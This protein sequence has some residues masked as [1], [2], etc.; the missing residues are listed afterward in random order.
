MSR[1]LEGRNAVV[2][3]A[4]RGIGFA[5]AAAFAEHGADVTIT[6]IDVDGG[7]LAESKLVHAG[8]TALFLKLDVSKQADVTALADAFRSQNKNVD[9]L[10]NN[11]GIVSEGTVAEVDLEHW[12]RLL[13]IDLTSVF[14]LVKAFLPSMTAR[15][16]GRVINIASVA[17][18]QGGGLLGNSCYAAAKGG[19]I[20][21]T[22]GIAREAGPSGVTCNVICPALTET[23]MT[24]SMPY[25]LRQR[26]IAAIPMGRGAKLEEIA[27][28]AVF[29]ASEDASF[30]TGVTLDV[31]GGFM[32][33]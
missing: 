4:A 11:A 6:D 3:G 10:V 33:A 15:R 5:I 32:R 12:Q 9:I 27:S 23:N 29:L 18:Q 20:A 30:V 13:S 25:E 7:K 17:G 14:L 19:V 26:V 22:K 1:K 8:L 24:A 21:F 2:T 31:D 16:W 28:V